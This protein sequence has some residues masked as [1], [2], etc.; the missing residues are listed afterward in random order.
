MGMHFMNPVP[1]QPGVEVIRGL[2]TSDDTGRTCTKIVEE[3]GKTRSQPKIKPA[4]AST[5]CSSPTS[6]RRSR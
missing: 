4:S 3:I 1:I 2:L 5:A 6:M